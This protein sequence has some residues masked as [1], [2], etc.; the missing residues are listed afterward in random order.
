MPEGKLRKTS[1]DDLYFAAWIAL[2]LIKTGP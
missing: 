2:G 1:K